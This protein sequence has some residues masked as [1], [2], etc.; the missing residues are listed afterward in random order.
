MLAAREVV[1]IAREP[2]D[3]VARRATEGVPRQDDRADLALGAPVRWADPFD[4]DIA[5]QVNFAL[6]RI[7]CLGWYLRPEVRF[8]DGAVEVRASVAKHER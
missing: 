7:R 6:P 4:D 8:P 1:D 3:P 5:S 2:Y